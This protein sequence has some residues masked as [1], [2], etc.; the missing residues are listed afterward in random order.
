[1]FCIGTVYMW[2]WG[3][4]ANVAA[5]SISI[6]LMLILLEWTTHTRVDSRQQNNFLLEQE[7]IM[8]ASVLRTRS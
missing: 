6:S 1:M 4:Y 3:G 8:R 5:G 7:R 2:F